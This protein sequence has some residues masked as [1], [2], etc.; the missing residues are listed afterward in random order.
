MLKHANLILDQKD[1][2]ITSSIKKTQKKSVC[3]YEEKKNRID[4]N[5]RGGRGKSNTFFLKV[6]QKTQ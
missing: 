5:I 2:K 6:S 1:P 3:F 4:N